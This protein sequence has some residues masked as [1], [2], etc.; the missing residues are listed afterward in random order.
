MS[1]HHL[2]DGSVFK[3]RLLASGVVCCSDPTLLCD[4]CEAALRQGGLRAA[5]SPIGPAPL[6]EWQRAERNQRPGNQEPS[7]TCPCGDPTANRTRS[8]Q[9]YRDRLTP[10]KEHR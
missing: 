4:A 8:N 9:L 5:T 3:P 1:V 6:D 7:P 2:R 10:T